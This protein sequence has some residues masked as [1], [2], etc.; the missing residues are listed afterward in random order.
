MSKREMDRSWIQQGARSRLIQKAPGEDITREASVGWISEIDGLVL[1]LGAG[2][3]RLETLLSHGRVIG[4]DENITLLK[5]SRM[6]VPSSIVFLAVVG[7]FFYLPFGH[8]SLDG[9]V[10]LNTL[11]N[12]PPNYVKQF[13]AEMLA[14]LKP[15]GRLIV[16]YRGGAGLRI[17]FSEMCI[18]AMGGDL[19]QY[20][21][22]PR[23]FISRLGSN[24]MVRITPLL[25]QPKGWRRWFGSPADARA[26]LI[27]DKLK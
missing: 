18:K 21:F 5:H 17:R 14:L 25:K 20:R 6:I 19:H 24:Y 1:D 13:L 9:I 8:E 7:S 16:S 23:K 11:E 15:S 4:L 27:V 22:N 10:C 2:E 26:L 3:G 12:Y